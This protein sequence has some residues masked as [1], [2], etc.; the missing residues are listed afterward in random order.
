MNFAKRSDL[1]NATSAGSRLSLAL[2]LVAF[3]AGCSGGGGGGGGLVTPPGIPKVDLHGD[4]A[5]FATLVLADGAKMHGAFNTFEDEDWFKFRGVAGVAY[6]LQLTGH[7]APAPDHGNPIALML[8]TLYKP[9]AGTQNLNSTGTD[10]GT[11]YDI[12]PILLEEDGDELVFG[13]SRITFRCPTT[14]VYYIRLENGVTTLGN[15]VIKLGSSQIGINVADVYTPQYRSVFVTD[16]DDGWVM[17][18]GVVGGLIGDFSLGIGDFSMVRSI[19]LAALLVPEVTFLDEDGVPEDDPQVPA[20][21]IHYGIPHATYPE[22]RFD[23]TP[24]DGDD[25]HPFAVDLLDGAKAGGDLSEPGVFESPLKIDGKETGLTKTVTKNGYVTTEDGT[26][27]LSFDIHISLD[28]SDGTKAIEDALEDDAWR[29]LMGFEWFADVHY[30]DDYEVD[31]EPVATSDA[32]GGAYNI[33]ESKLVLT[34][35]SVVPPPLFPRPPFTLHF[36]AALQT[37]QVAFQQYSLTSRDYMG[38]PGRPR[39]ISP[40]LADQYAGG[41]IDIHSGA[42]G[43]NGPVILELGRVPNS[44]PPPAYHSPFDLPGGLGRPPGQRHVVKILS[45]AEMDRFRQAY[46]FGSGIYVDVHTAENPPGAARADIFLDMA[47][48]GQTLFTKSGENAEGSV[49]FVSDYLDGGDIT[50]VANGEIQ[51]TIDHA[52]T[53]TPECGAAMPGEAVSVNLAPETYYYR[54]VAEDGTEWDGLVT[55]EDG[56]CETITLGVE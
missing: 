33:F 49:T 41:V 47:L 53:S 23:L 35:Q 43:T 26:K 50:V 6:T 5:G 22:L 9:D 29:M 15:Y 48:D 14:S 28:Q 18:D 56:S 10:G 7:P 38:G 1:S 42:P 27:M 45:D 16:P 13:D 24:I 32:W 39:P 44:V 17:F 3:L 21:H 52:S 40:T 30:T 34:S 55:I 25:P 36:D 37:F 8:V 46:Y 12:D 4:T 31:P 54:A 51:G 19:G 11:Q 2:I 20:A